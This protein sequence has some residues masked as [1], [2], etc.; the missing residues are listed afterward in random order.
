MLKNL[1]ASLPELGRIKSG[2]KGKE[3]IS[4]GGKKFRL[5]EKIDHYLI[6]T[7]AR[8]EDGNYVLDEELMNTL[9]Q[10]GSGAKLDKNGNIV[11]IPIRLLYNTIDLNFNTRLACYVSGKCACSGDG[12]KGVTRA[13]RET[14]CPCEKLDPTYTGK[15]KC[16]F[17]GKLY[18]IIEGTTAVGA[19][20]TL[21]STSYNTVKSILGGLAFIQAAAGGQLAF[22][23]LLLVLTPKTTVIPTTGATTTVY[24]SSIVYNG[25][26]NEL[27]QSALEMAK[28]KSQYL[29]EMDKVEETA[30]QLIIS[31]VESEEEQ[32]EIQ[33][34]FYPEAIIDQGETAK[35][36][37][38]KKTEPEIEEKIESEPEKTEPE[39]EP[40]TE[41]EPEKEEPAKKK[42]GR[43]KKIKEEEP[44]PE[45]EP[46]TKSDSQKDLDDHSD[47]VDISKAP[48]PIDDNQK[49]EIVRLKKSLKITD[50]AKWKGLLE[51]FHVESALSLT[52]EEANL[53]IKHL[54]KMDDVPF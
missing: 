38:N 33:Q 25:N 15:E 10:E 28:E 4:K 22:L 36:R 7:M 18:C 8:D 13:G 44:K 6:T 29:I 50:D 42:H 54:R 46:E 40:D 47:V 53:F 37:D 2:R 32:L 16:K 49:R 48:V 34:E 39:A 31:S 3:A 27:R 45:P 5:P 14:Q 11:G 52:T 21:H 30:R 51:A 1:Q 20:H 41:P 43:P 9:K 26:I 17:N 19:C 24:V 23:P 35:A 12:E